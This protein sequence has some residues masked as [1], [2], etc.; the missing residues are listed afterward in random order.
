MSIS[1]NVVNNTG[2]A[3]GF[4]SYEVHKRIRKLE[5]RLRG[6]PRDTVH[7]QVILS[8][9][10]HAEAYFVALNLRLPSD[11]LHVTETST[12]PFKA[13]DAAVRA[14]LRRLAKHRSNRRVDHGSPG[15]MGGVATSPAFTDEP[16]TK[17]ASPQT[18]A[19]LVADV[20]EADYARLSRFVGRQLDEYV[21]AGTLPNGAIDPRDIVDGVAE[22][23]LR[24]PRLKPKRTTYPTWFSSLAFQQTRQ[25]VRQFLEEAELS[26]PTDLDVEPETDVTAD[27]LEPE[28]VALHVLH[29]AIEPEEAA[30]ADYIPDPT[31][32]PPDVTVAEKDMVA[33]LRTIARGWP[34]LDREVFEMH[35]LEGL[36]A[37]DIGLALQCDGRD[38]ATCLE[39]IQNTLRRRLLQI[40][41]SVGAPSL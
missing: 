5:G 26:V 13:L 39:R 40:T 2:E 41:D 7:L 8:E 23:V 19:D 32:T 17:G 25:A 15:S 27:G 20:L 12:T 33:T 28:E 1:W 10:G 14:L 38:V 4:V 22:E 37:D 29:D 24:E 3:S 34:K 30:L 16:L 36:S 11:I 31:A 21:A 35:Y 6:F 18:Q 9:R